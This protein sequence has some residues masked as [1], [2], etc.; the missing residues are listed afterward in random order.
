MRI[1]DY[2]R[3]PRDVTG[4]MWMGENEEEKAIQDDRTQRQRQRQ[5]PAY[6]C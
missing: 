4:Q 5:R 2:R 1:R 6:H 3:C